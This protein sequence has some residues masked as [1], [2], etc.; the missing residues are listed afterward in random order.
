MNNHYF[1]NHIIRLDSIDSTNNYAAKLLNQTKIPF[2]AVIM[3]QFQTE[4][5]GQRGAKWNGEKGE[6][7]TFSII[8]DGKQIKE[9]PTF[10][11]SKCVAISVKEM[12]SQN[13]RENVMLKWP[14][15]IYVNTK[16]IAG[17]LIENQ[18][19]GG[20][21]NSSV[22]GVGI[23][24]NQIN[25]EDE[26]NAISLKS[27]SGQDYDLEGLLFQFCKHLNTNY[28]FLLDG[29]FEKIN[30]HYQSSLYF[31]NKKSQFLIEGKKEDVIIRGVNQHGLIEL[32]KL[33]GE[34][35]YYCFNE[36]RQ[37]L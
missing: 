17:I 12:L 31:L 23:N 25:F 22:V 6:N 37:I 2:G 26:L 33:N 21:L 1:G 36:A 10:L 14:N 20:C 34:V 32:E 27:I 28:S 19:K 4:G 18:W 9:Y 5:R 7:L 8:V 35:G 11:L 30:E 3:S 29:Q 24:V 15:D 13:T 16:K